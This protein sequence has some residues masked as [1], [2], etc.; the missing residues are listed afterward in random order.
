MQDYQA[1][2]RVTAELNQLLHDQT[3]LEQILSGIGDLAVVVIPAC[4]EAGVTLEQKGK[5]VAR[6][7]TGDT[8]RTVDAYQY[9]IDEGPCIHASETGSKVLIKDMKTEDRWPRFASFAHSRGVQSS[10][11]IPMIE[12]GEQFGVLN[13]YSTNDPFG[14]PDEEIGS[15]FAREATNAV[16]HVAAF[17][18]TRELIDN[19]RSAL[20]TR[21]VIGA[22]VGILM[23][24]DSVGINEAF[25]KLVGISQR[26]NMKLR[27]VAERMTDVYEPDGDRPI[28]GG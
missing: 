25:E 9:D 12:G 10:Y 21:S 23:V 5:V 2:Y 27:D 17:S 6:T 28:P 16:R 22:A 3:P 4:E 14:A 26:D 19:L 11:S 20:E 8:A 24:R 13:L 15:M 18:K 1:I 7:T